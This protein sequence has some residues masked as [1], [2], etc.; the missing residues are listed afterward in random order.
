MAEYQIE[1]T[2]NAKEDLPVYTTFECQTSF[3]PFGFN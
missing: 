1:V 3:L 2:E